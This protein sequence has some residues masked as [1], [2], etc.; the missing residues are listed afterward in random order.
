M[1]VNKFIVWIARRLRVSP[2]IAHVLVMAL[3]TVGYGLA[4]GWADFRRPLFPVYWLG[5]CGLV[6][7]V[8]WLTKG[9]LIKDWVRVEPW[10][11]P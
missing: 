6:V 10:Q 11:K 1:L 9:A 8:T 3:V 2:L 5:I 7:L 4:T